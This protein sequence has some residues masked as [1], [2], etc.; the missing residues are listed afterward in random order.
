M[1]S[2]LPRQILGWLIMAPD[3]IESCDLSAGDFPA[4]RYR[5]CFEIVTRMWEDDRPDFI[6]V[7]ILAERLGGDGATSFIN[8]LT[9]GLQR[10][11]DKSF[12]AIV[13]KMKQQ[14]IAARILAKV[15]RQAQAGELD[16]EEVKGDLAEYERLRDSR[17]SVNVQENLISGAALQVL[18]VESEWAVEKLVPGRSITLLHSPG[19]LGKTWFSLGMAN[20]V[21]QGCPFLRLTTKQRPVCYIDF[22]NPLP[23]LIDRARKLDIRET[24]FWHISATNPPPKLDTAA[25][26]L[27]RQLQT[28]SLIIFDT[29]RAAH[30][31]DEN[32]SQDMSL[33][34]GRLKELREIGLDIFL[35]HHTSKANERQYKGSTAISDLADHVLKLY[36]TRSGSLAEID[37]NGEPDPDATFVLATGKTRFEPFH[38][39]LTFNPDAGGFAVT[40]DPNLEA[41]DA[42]TGY[43]AGPGRGQNQTEIIKWAKSE[44][45]GPT[46]RTSFLT[47]LSRG[48]REGRWHSRKVQGARGMK[49][50]Y[51]PII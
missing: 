30:D 25:Y 35:I 33:I 2:A 15:E 5:Q 3:L 37:D 22:E 34:M 6:P 49:R 47:L 8:T 20:A 14:S 10:P 43:I 27:Y 23:L 13:R 26:T 42:L 46:M 38:L 18:E 36:R 28:G 50:I 16:L 17:S 31:G 11:T 21:S 19:G 7:I 44:G 24:R 9:D 51:E 45:V 40:E 1:N 29:L 32:S 12:T 48:E 41:L 4:G 39:F